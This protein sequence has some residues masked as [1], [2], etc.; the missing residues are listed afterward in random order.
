MLPI[1]I[2]AEAVART[3]TSRKLAS[4]L[5][6]PTLDD[7]DGEDDEVSAGVVCLL[8]DT[9]RPKADFVEYFRK[10]EQIDRLTDV[11]E[12]LSIEVAD[13]FAKAARDVERTFLLRH[14]ISD[15]FLYPLM[16]IP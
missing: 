15:D 9:C 6:G 2:K 10:N 11:L 5:S 12:Q 16:F 7:D 13:L 1:V 8:L 3:G 4:Q 14:S